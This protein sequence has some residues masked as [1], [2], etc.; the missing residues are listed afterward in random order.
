M[1]G[2]ESFSPSGMVW[3]ISKTAHCGKS[4]PLLPLGLPWISTHAPFAGGG[5][6]LRWRCCSSSASRYS[7]RPAGMPHT[8]VPCFRRPT[9]AALVEGS[10]RMCTSGACTTR[11]AR[12]LPPRR[13]RTCLTVPSSSLARAAPGISSWPPSMESKNLLSSS[14][15]SADAVSAGGLPAPRPLS[16]MTAGSAGPAGA[17]RPSIALWPA[18]ARPCGRGLLRASSSWLRPPRPPATMA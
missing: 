9:E 5:P 3:P 16:K 18:A 10:S 7:Q 8:I 2:Q 17:R 12:G 1:P 13:A 11:C 15:A 14:A 4:W 6:L